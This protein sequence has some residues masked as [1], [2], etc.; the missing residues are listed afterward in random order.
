MKCYLVFA[1]KIHLI[2]IS[3]VLEYILTQSV[4]IDEL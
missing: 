2:G 1:E 4:E 3:T